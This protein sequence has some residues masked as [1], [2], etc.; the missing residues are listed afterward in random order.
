MTARKERREVLRELSLVAKLALPDDSDSETECAHPGFL[1]CIA[2][3]VARNLFTPPSLVGSWETRKRARLVS[4]PEASMDEDAP[5]L[6]FVRDVRTSREVR[7]AD[8]EASAQAVQEA[9]DGSL[10]LCV[11]LPDRLHSDRGLG[12]DVL[13]SRC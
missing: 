1:A 4:V 5:A 11:T 13:A 7:W 6:R 2:R 12:C 10:G 9:A 3:F 8:A